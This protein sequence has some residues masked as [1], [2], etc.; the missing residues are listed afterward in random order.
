MVSAL[1]SWLVLLGLEL[2]VSQN[3]T[4]SPE[5][6]NATSNSNPNRTTMAS[7]TS[8]TKPTGSGLS[9]NAGTGSFLVPVI[10]AASLLQRYC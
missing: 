6:G 7:A 3:S 2:V 4:M 5:T 10:T 8:T 9:L 1:P